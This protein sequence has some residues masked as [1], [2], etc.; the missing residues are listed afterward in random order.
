LTLHHSV[1]LIAHHKKECAINTENVR[2]NV[3]LP[4]DLYESLN[5]IAGA[6]SRSRLISE[7]LREYILKI[8]KI[9]Q[10]KQLEEGYRATAKEAIDLAEEFTDLYLDGWDE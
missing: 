5:Q 10:E 4:K 6:R 1:C 2:I 3:S 8:E 9:E 7:S